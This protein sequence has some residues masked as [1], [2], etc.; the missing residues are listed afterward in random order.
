VSWTRVGAVVLA[1]YASTAR[2]QIPAGTAFTYQGRL[3][4][5]GVPASGP[6]DLQLTLFDAPSGGA[7]VGG[8]IVVEDV[9]VSGG[10]FTA[11]LDFGPGAFTG[12]ARWLE[13]GVRPGPSI[14]PFT[15]L[16]PRQALTPAPQAIYSQTAPWSGLAGMPAGFA[17]GIDD[18]SGGDITAVT[19]GAGLVGGASSGDAALDVS[20]GGSGAAATV[21]R[22]DHDHM[23]QA[24]SGS[25]PTALGVTTSG[26]TGLRGETSSA[27]G[28]GV[29]GLSSAGTGITTGVW[30][31]SAS[32]QGRGV[33]GR[34]LATSGSAYGV[35]GESFSSLGRGVYGLASATTGTTYGVIGQAESSAGVGVY[36]LHNATS[37]IGA[38]LQGETSST[39]SSAVAVLG[40]VTSPSPGSNSAAVRGIN[41]GTGGLGI[42]VWGSHAG[43]GWGVNG[44]TVSGVGVRGTASSSAGVGVRAQGGGTNGTAL[45][46]AGG[47]IR[48]AG[49]GV[50]TN[51]AATVLVVG[52]TLGCTSGFSSFMVL[53]NSFA[54]DDPDAIVFVTPSNG[55]LTA[56]VR[57]N[58]NLP[59][60]PPNRW[61][62]DTS[63]P[64]IDV[65]DRY[66][67]LIIK[68]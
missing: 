29:F 4:D 1:L 44:T 59:S 53:D 25:S 36:G 32:V 2:A 49:A 18:D 37:G 65:G 45:E 34:A 56:S 23:G 8:P 28:R 61:L 51:T 60:C 13:I 40:H 17:D 52:M 3:T 64:S 43:G 7:A 24:W 6:Y 39:S 47:A 58:T 15:T 31:E 20:F 35:S 12:S 11:G 66:N 48:V 21:A 26:L 16:T 63:D 57:Y 33:L 67:I 55:V 22:S 41:E 10:L 54:N 14:G 42:G 50:G 62:V 9:A 38:G 30:G 68:P 19:A 46:V 5:G 27:V